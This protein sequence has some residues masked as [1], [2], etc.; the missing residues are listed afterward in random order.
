MLYVG[1]SCHKWVEVYFFKSNL[2]WKSD[3]RL[4]TCALWFTSGYLSSEVKNS[5]AWVPTNSWWG[6]LEDSSRQS[7]YPRGK[8]SSICEDWAFFV[9]S[10]VYLWYCDVGVISWSPEQDDPDTFHKW[11][12]AHRRFAGFSGALSNPLICKNKGKCKT[13]MLLERRFVRL[14]SRQCTL[15][16]FIESVP[17]SQKK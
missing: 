3:D 17:F 12:E 5:I 16:A 13:N 11:K 15:S 14:V 1:F 2:T 8:P 6:P 9:E 4:H 7:I 10:E